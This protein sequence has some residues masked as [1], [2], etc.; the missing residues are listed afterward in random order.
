VFDICDMISPRIGTKPV[1]ILCRVS[2]HVPAMIRTDPGRFR[3]VIVNLMGNA[4][5]FTAK[6]E[7][8]LSL[9]VVEEEEERQK[10]H[11]KVRDTGIGIPK[12]KLDSVFEVFQQADG[13]TTRKYGGTGLGLSICRQIAHLMNGDVWVESEVDVGSVFH[14]TCWVERSRKK[15]RKDH[16][17]KQ[18]SGM[19]ALIV[20]DN[21]TN[22]DI[23]SNTLKRAGMD[24]EQ[25]ADSREVLPL[26]KK[27]QEEK[28][29][30][31]ICI[32]DIQMPRVSGY[33]I[34]EMVRKENK[35]ISDIPL[36]A[37]S[38]STMSRSKKFRD[39]G[40][41]GFLPKPIHR[42]KLLRMVER[43]LGLVDESETEKQERIVTQHSIVEEAKHSVHILL[44]EDNP[45]NMKLARFM[46]E[47]AGYQLSVAT[48]GQ[49]AVDM[50]T[51]N[52]DR[53]DL[54]L[55]DIQMPELDGK[56]ATAAIRKKGF[57]DIPIVAMTAEAMKGDREKCIEAGMNDYIAKPIKREAVFRIVKKWINL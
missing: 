17:Q 47:K 55:M 45:V 44:A 11:V 46:L 13:S 7:V 22:L 23:L 52:P 51:A 3:Q 8:E 18:L 42:T 10:L 50:F 2:E 56:E 20:D 25:L 21:Y 15:V 38:S 37:F 26:L 36:L 1:E 57:S 16:E 43:L 40:F 41:N 9:D 49:E 39:V 24:V 12:D 34:A 35:P 6:G 33:E 28:N 27:R 48:N 4:V 29:P 19:R 54:I 30:F 5:K 14:F 31:H 53:Y 32:L